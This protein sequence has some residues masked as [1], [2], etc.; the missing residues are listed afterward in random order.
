MK[1]YKIELMVLDMDEI[2]AE[3]IRDVLENARYPNRCISPEVK[4]I[5]ERDIGEFHDDHPLNHTATADAE[6][7]RL[8]TYVFFREHGF[9]MLELA[10]DREARQNAIFNPGTIRVERVT[11]EVVYPPT[12]EP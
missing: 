11:G 5:E 2:G 4:S 12:T 10:N 1:V 6:Y 3:Q 8:F 7:R 9:Y